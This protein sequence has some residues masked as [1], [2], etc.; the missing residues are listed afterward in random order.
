MMEKGGYTRDHIF[1]ADET[2]LWWKL[3]PSKSLVSGGEI[4]VKNFKQSK[5]RVLYLLALML[6]D[7]VNFRWTSYIRVPGLVASKTLIWNASQLAILHT[8]NPGWMQKFFD[9]GFNSNSYLP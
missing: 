7:L 9:F 1:N 8:K 6:L 4:N 5:D 2:G 3:M